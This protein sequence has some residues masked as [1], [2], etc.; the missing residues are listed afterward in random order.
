L[1]EHAAMQGAV[2]TIA[3]AGS[4]HDEAAEK[5]GRGRSV[6]GG[7]AGKAQATEVERERALFGQT[8]SFTERSGITAAAAQGLGGRGKGKVATAFAGVGL[9][10]PR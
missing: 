9:A 2:G 10:G 8:E 5:I 4:V 6:R 3:A 7:V 1:A